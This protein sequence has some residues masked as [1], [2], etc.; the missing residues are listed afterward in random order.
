MWSFI[1]SFMWSLLSFFISSVQAHD[2]C[3]KV[4]VTLCFGAAGRA[5]GAPVTAALLLCTGV[6]PV[7]CGHY[8]YRTHVIWMSIITEASS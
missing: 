3:E 1:F 5:G 7:T 8:V 6:F 2:A 4:V